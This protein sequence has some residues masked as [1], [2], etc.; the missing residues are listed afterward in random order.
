VEGQKMSKSLGNYY[1][2]RQVLE[3]GYPAEAIR[4]LLASVPYRKQLNFTFEGLKAAVT[5][6]E[7]LRN[8]KL[9]LDTDRFAEGANPALSAR[10]AEALAQFRAG[11][12]E[13]MN[14]AGALADTNTLMDTGEFRA[15][16]AA[17]AAELLSLFDSVFDVL[18]PSARQGALA[19]AEI[20]RLA[21][22]RTQAKR[23]RDFARADQIRDQLLQQGIILE[24]TKAGVRW[25]RK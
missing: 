6:I 21:G 11:M 17:E 8:Y 2:L 9:R 10:A 25:K 4:Y 14:T 5:A 23:S 16:N 15:G 24:D 18:R 19:D 12:D 1:T 7:R 13:D 3:R 20:E 22:E